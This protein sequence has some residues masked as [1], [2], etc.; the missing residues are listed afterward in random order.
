VAVQPGIAITARAR[1]FAALELA[2]PISFKPANEGRGDA[3]ALIA[4]CDEGAFP[5]RDDMAGTGLPTLVVGGERDLHAPLGEV[6]LSECDAVDQRIRGVSVGDTVEGPGLG[7]LDRAQEVL[8]SARSGPAWT[9]S[10]G[11][12]PV[13]RVRC[14]LPELGPDQALR[15]LF[16]EHALTL[17]ALV[18]FL[19]T[20]TD[21]DSF[22]SPK[23]RAVILFDDPNLR[24]RTYGF[25]DYRQLLEHADAHGYHASMAMIPL[26]V[27]GQHRATV[28]LFRKHADR[29]S[30]VL[31]GNNHV[32][33]EL[34][35][36]VDDA[37]AIAIAAQAMRRA[38]RFES[39]YG[40]GI[41]RVM[42]PPHGMCGANIARAL[43]A[44]GFDALCAIHPLPWTERTPAGR[45]LAGWD[46]AEFAE[47]CAVIPRIPLKTEFSEIAL[48]A[49]L[50]HPL[51][52]YGHHGDLSEGLDLLAATASRVNRLGEVQWTSLGE[53]AATNHSIRLDGGIVRVRP[54]SHRLRVNLP[55]GAKSL[56]V[57]SPRDLNQGLAG[58]SGE[59][60]PTVPFD[61]S[62]PCEPGK[63]EIHLKP[64]CSIDPANVPS[65]TPRVWPILRRAATE[66]RDRLRPLLQVGSV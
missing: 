38:A 35:Q 16:T 46:P 10:R 64:L 32:A 65:P 1:L 29:L 40:L 3:D 50:G 37:D 47:G 11:S 24:W 49:F 36:P 4:I 57:E 54:Y 8:A 18:Q 39:R 41:D 31:H 43:G 9:K 60:S 22:S 44:L 5:S 53:I 56:V 15:D 63:L 45:P 59:C 42:T 21:A 23:L 52:L 17:I 48:R 30:L 12:A 14:A 33:R 34:M 66:A 58:W 7:P 51:V 61:S 26:D 19:R 20:V 25:I 55:R 28:D 62:M 27:W 13:H 6:L 2:F